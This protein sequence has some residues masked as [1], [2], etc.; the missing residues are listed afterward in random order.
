MKEGRR[1]VSIS[2]PAVVAGAAGKGLSSSSKAVVEI[3]TK[4]ARK[5]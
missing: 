3:L 4:C 1:L 5:N 2:T